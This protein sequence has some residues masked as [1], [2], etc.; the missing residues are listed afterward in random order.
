MQYGFLRATVFRNLLPSESQSWDRCFVHIP[1]AQ[2]FFD[3]EG[4]ESSPRP[5]IGE[6]KN[7]ISLASVIVWLSAKLSF[8]RSFV[9][10][11]DDVNLG[12]W[13]QPSR[14]LQHYPD[15]SERFVCAAGRPRTNRQYR[16][17]TLS[18][19][20]KYSSH[21]FSERHEIPRLCRSVHLAAISS[22][23]IDV[24]ETFEQIRVMNT[25]SVKWKDSH[26]FVAFIFSSKPHQWVV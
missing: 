12:H 7:K 15:P 22:T 5:L 24:L 2:L 3:D 9:F 21:I 16:S 19:W 13:L 25:V 10:H 18:L 17:R 8:I 20:G 26:A 1:H 4:Y 23:L 6:S 11:I 14:G